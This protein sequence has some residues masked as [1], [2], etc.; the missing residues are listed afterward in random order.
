MA[1]PTF[2]TGQGGSG[3]V[4]GA[5]LR[6]LYSEALEAARIH[7][8]DVV[9]LMQDARAYDL[10]QTIRRTSPDAWAALSAEQLDTAV[11]LA[12]IAA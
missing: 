11:D 7:G 4:R 9:L 2:G 1:L 10:A 3:P 12:G 6:V 5:I 8:F